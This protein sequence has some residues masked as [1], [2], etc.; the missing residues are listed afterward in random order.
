MNILDGRIV[1]RFG[2]YNFCELNKKEGKLLYKSMLEHGVRRFQIENHIPIV[3]PE[4]FV[5]E[6]T[7]LKS[8]PVT[9]TI[10]EIEFTPAALTRAEVVAAGGRH[11]KY[12]AD[13]YHKSVHNT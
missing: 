5:N 2:Q 13:L 12:A 4:G 3:V 8:A 9:N 11:R 6:I 1:L 10:P 7:L